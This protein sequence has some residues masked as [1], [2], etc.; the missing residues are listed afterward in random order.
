MAEILRTWV[1]LNCEH[2]FDAWEPNPECPDCG[3]VRVSWVPGGGHTLGVAPGVDAEFRKLTDTFGMTD[4][5]S[6]GNGAKVRASQPAV[7]PNSAPLHHFAPGFACTPD[8]SRPVCVPT[9]AQVK[10]NHKL[11]IGQALS[12]NGNFPSLKSNTSVEA[13]HRPKP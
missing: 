1:C 5:A 11:T 4:M 2:Q 10:A 8:P 7:A 3:C 13:S 9:S 6:G 12:P